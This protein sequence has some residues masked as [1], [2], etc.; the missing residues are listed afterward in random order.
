MGATRIRAQS[1]APWHLCCKPAYMTADPC[2][3]SFPFLKGRHREFRSVRSHHRDEAQT[4]VDLGSKGISI[5][6][7]R[8]EKM[9]AVRFEFVK[10]LEAQLAGVQAQ[11]LRRERNQLNDDSRR[12]LVDASRLHRFTH[13]LSLSRLTRTRRRGSRSQRR[14]QCVSKHPFSARSPKRRHQLCCRSVS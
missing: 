13:R 5:N 7:L 12:L 1:L 2:I 4:L 10:A 14:R 8:A 11:G 9:V 3:R 6:A